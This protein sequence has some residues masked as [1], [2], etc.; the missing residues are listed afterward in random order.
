[1]LFVSGSDKAGDQESNL[2]Q[3]HRSEPG[4]FIDLFLLIEYPYYQIWVYKSKV[5]ILLTSLMLSLNGSIKEKMSS[6]RD[7]LLT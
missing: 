3:G 4:G 7:V 5:T 6:L 2:R 1:M